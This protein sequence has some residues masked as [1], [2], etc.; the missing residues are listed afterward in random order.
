LG[1][2]RA[3]AAPAV[4]TD[5]ADRCRPRRVRHSQRPWTAAIS[6]SMKR[7]RSAQL[8]RSV[9]CHGAVLCWWCPTRVLRSPLVAPSFASVVRGG[10]ETECRSSK[11][12]PI[13]LGR[14]QYIRPAPER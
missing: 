11:N 6:S 4:R 5:S 7:W 9:R 8:L 14:C 12:S 3:S 1:L 13:R 2:T 10:V